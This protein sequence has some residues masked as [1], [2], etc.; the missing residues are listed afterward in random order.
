MIPVQE[1]LGSLDTPGVSSVANGR[2]G[3]IDQAVATLAPAPQ[4]ESRHRFNGFSRDGRKP[5]NS[6][7]AKV[8]ID[9]LVF[10][11]SNSR[12]GEREKVAD[13][14]DMDSVDSMFDNPD[15]ESAF[16]WD[17]ETASQWHA[18][19]GAIDVFGMMD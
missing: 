9:D 6:E 14:R 12:C 18:C 1:N 4:R 15:D 10:A 5:F 8:A 19:T 2:A 3:A 16:P 13:Y 17:D 11:L 7:T